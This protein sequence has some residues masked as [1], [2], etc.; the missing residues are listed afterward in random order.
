MFKNTIAKYKQEISKVKHHRKLIDIFERSKKVGN[1]PTLFLDKKIRNNNSEDTRR[2]HFDFR[3]LTF[4]LT[5][6]V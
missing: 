2:V 3:Q 1:V 4:V 5:F 6:D